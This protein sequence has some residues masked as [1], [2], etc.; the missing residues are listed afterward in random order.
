VSSYPPKVGGPVIREHERD[1]LG[2]V[3]VLDVGR[4]LGPAEGQ[5][6]AQHVVAGDDVAR[7]PLH[8]YR[9]DLSEPREACRHR[10]DLAEARIPRMQ[11][12]A[13]DRNRKGP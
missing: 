8:D 6:R 3:E 13:V 1:R 2:V 12:D 7:A 11:L 5:R 9:F 4:D 10:G